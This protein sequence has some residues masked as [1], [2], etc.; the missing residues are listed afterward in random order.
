MAQLPII[1]GN[2][3]ENYGVRSRARRTIGT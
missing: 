1:H 2:S 3:F